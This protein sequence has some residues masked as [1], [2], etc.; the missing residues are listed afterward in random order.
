MSPSLTK[1]NRST[2]KTLKCLAFASILIAVFSALSLSMVKPASAQSTPIPSVPQFTVQYVDNSYTTP[3]TYQV[4]QF[5]GQN[6][7]TNPG[8]YVE[9]KDFVFTIQNQPFTAYVDSNG[10]NISLCYNLRFKGP[11]GTDWT[12]FPFYD[13]GEGV[14]RCIE[15]IYPMYNPDLQASNTQYTTL[16]E[17]MPTLFYDTQTPT[18]GNQV[19]FQVQACMGYVDYSGG[20]GFYCFSGQ[21]SDWSQTQT[22]TLGASSTATP[23]DYHN[24][25]NSTAPIQT[26]PPSPTP[27][28]PQAPEFPA[29]AILLAVLLV[30][31]LSFAALSRRKKHEAGTCVDRL[32]CS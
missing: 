16:T 6:Q 13:T 1:R 4:N 10:N 20:D 21:R 22:I 14:R 29:P 18:D 2:R 31:P 9:N 11:Y 17:S 8:E 30:L 32:T 26:A 15:F 24:T 5:T 28:S 19:E 3:P 25:Q 12:Y 23:Q 7:I 27:A